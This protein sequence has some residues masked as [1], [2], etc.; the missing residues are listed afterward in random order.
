MYNTVATPILE[1]PFGLVKPV[2]NSQLPLFSGSVR[3]HS[4][5]HTLSI[6]GNRDKIWKLTRYYGVSSDYRVLS[7]GLFQKRFNQVGDF[8][9]SVLGFSVAETEFM[10]R[11]LEYWTHYGKCYPKI[12]DV[13]EQPGCSRSTAQRVL[14]RLKEWGL[15]QVI[16]RYLQPYRRQISSLILLHGLLLL[17]ARYLAEHGVAFFEKWLQPYLTMPGSQFWG[18]LSASL[19]SSC[20][21]S[22]DL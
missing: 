2:V 9:H 16:H 5:V 17:I 20:H 13:C 18:D 3:H 11:Y 1:H 10:M 21:G 6:Y 8:F 4:N 22:P 15:I 14:K 7:K 12:A 19:S